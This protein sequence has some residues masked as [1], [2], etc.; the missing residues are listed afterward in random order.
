MMYRVDCEQ[1]AQRRSVTA[2][3]TNALMTGAEDFLSGESSY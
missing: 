1:V 2:L 3:A